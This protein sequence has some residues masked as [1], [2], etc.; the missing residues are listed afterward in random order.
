VLFAPGRDTL[1]TIWMEPVGFGWGLRE[2]Q[3][4]HEVMGGRDMR[5]YAIATVAL[6]TLAIAPVA[7]GEADIM[8]RVDHHYVDS[9]GVKIHYVSIGEGPVI[10]FVHG[11]P[12]FWYSWREQMDGLSDR[13]RCVAMDNRAYNKSDNPTG[14]ENYDIDFLVADVDAVIDDLGVESVTLV[15]HDWGGFISW[16]YTFAHQE[17]VNKLIVMNLPHPRGLTRELATNE[18]QQKNSGYAR[19]FQAPGAHEGI[20][21]EMLAANF[22]RPDPEVGKRY[23][24]AFRNTDIEGALNYYKANFPREPYVEM[25]DFPKVTSP[26][27]QFHGLKDTA[28]HHYGLNKT[29]EWLDA[30]YTLVTVPEAGHWVQHDASEMVTDTMKWWLAM[31]K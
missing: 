23:L 13:Y 30:D 22:M 20:K 7:F 11:F 14:V 25:T 17:K 10:L 16:Y 18:V 27:L 6:A 21:P 28:L 31:R 4:I 8:D 12:D 29:W 9:D 24:E 5:A 3:N 2:N 26:V 15:G 1:S 19:R